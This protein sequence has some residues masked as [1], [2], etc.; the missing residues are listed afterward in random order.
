MQFL[1]QSAGFQGV[2]SQDGNSR[3]AVPGEEVIRGDPVFQG[4]SIFLNA[5]LS[6]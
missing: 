6:L 3:M 1:Y 2:G 4:I 5:V